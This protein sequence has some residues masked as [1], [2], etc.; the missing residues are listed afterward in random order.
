MSGL[1]NS[2]VSLDIQILRS[3]K[4]GFAG[5]QCRFQV[6]KQRAQRI[7][8]LQVR[9]VSASMHRSLVMNTWA[10]SA[11]YRCCVLQIDICILK[12]KTCVSVAIFTK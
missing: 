5:S 1:K 11:L 7:I 2:S 3:R 4:H 9:S 6:F 10:I 12:H 8:R